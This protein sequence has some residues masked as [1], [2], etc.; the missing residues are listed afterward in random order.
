MKKKI[1]LTSIACILLC[2]CS[3]FVTY[4]YLISQ[5]KANN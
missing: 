1:L 2:A 4:A 3:V 5:D